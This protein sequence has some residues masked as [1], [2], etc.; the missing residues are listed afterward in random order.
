VDM[1]WTQ[2]DVEWQTFKPFPIFFLN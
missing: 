1:K 2:S